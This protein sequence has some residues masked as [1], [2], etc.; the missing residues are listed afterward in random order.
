MK[1]TRLEGYALCAGILSRV[2]R[3]SH[4]W[5]GAFSQIGHSVVERLAGFSQFGYRL[6]LASVCEGRSPLRG[7][8]ILHNRVAGWPAPERVLSPGGDRSSIMTDDVK[9]LGSF[10]RAVLRRIDALKGE[11]FAAMIAGDLTQELKRHVALPQV[12]LAVERLL[13]R[14]LI[15]ATMS[16]T[17]PKRGGKAR[18]LFKLEPS[19]TRALSIAAAAVCTSSQQESSNDPQKFGQPVPI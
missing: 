8:D 19:G 4:D 6:E 5:F 2:R 3:S 14:G 16:E 17:L 1:T 13:G 12:Y 11:A 9:A 10:E 15:S 18:R 7:P